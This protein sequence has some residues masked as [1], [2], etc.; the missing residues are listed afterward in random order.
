MTTVEIPRVKGAK[1]L[2][3]AKYITDDVRR[4]VVRA[5]TECRRAY[6]NEPITVRPTS[7]MPGPRPG[8]VTVCHGPGQR[9]YTVVSGEVQQA[10]P[11][12]LLAQ[13]ARGVREREAGR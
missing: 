2:R 1:W 13:A 11:D 7:Y 12:D 9:I 8:L 4:E 5:I 3:E 6:P 10:E